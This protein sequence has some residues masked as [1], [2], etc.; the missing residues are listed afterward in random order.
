MEERQA[1]YGTTHR[2]ER[3]C[4][5]KF[6]ILQIRPIDKKLNNKTKHGKKIY[7]PKGKTY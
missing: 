4:T 5:I 3:L 2:L 1:L 6:I 7:M